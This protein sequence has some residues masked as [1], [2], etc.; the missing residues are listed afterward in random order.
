[1]SLILR[2]VGPCTCPGICEGNCQAKIV[3]Q[4]PDIP[5]I[6]NK[7]VFDLKAVLKRIYCINLPESVERRKEMLKMLKTI[8][9]SDSGNY[10]SIIFI[11]AISPTD[12][13]FKII[14]SDHKKV[15]NDYI[16]RCYCLPPKNSLCRRHPARPLREVE[17]AIS[18]SHLQAYQ[19]FLQNEDK[20]GLVCED[21]VVLLPNIINILSEVLEPI[22]DELLSDRPIIVF[23]GGTKNNKGLLITDPSHFT[24]RPS[25]NGVYSNYAYILNQTA[26]QILKQKAFPINRPDDSYKRYLIVKNKITAYQIV[27]SLV[28]ELSSGINGPAVYNRLSKETSVKALEHSIKNEIRRNKD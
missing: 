14:R 28:A 21:D 2:K 8:K 25:K 1:M 7:K 13:I 20:L 10:L 6:N 16:P 27:P 9:S 23:C 18:L 12:K 3:L 26:A 17:I 24:L 22:K 15:N 19:M 5:D 4:I 11:K